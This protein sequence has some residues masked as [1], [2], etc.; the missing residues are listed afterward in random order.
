MAW[1]ATSATIGNVERGSAVFNLFDVIS[2]KPDA[3]PSCAAVFTC[4]PI[5]LEHGI[6]PSFVLCR[7]VMAGVCPASR[8]K[9]GELVS[10]SG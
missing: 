2:N 9:E 8:G 6:A 5:A 10:C 4:E 1:L 7:L 3:A